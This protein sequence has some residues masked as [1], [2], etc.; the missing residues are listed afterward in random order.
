VAAVLRFCVNAYRLGVKPLIPGSCRYTPGCS[1][2]ALEALV[3]HGALRG[4]WLSLRRIGRC[5]PWGGFGYDPV[6]GDPVAT[7]MRAREDRAMGAR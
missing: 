7:R 3:R 2:Y 1:E 4:G 6:P 5:H